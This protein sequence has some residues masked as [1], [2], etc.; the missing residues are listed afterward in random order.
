MWDLWWTKWP[1]DR[2]FP[3]ASASPAK[4]QSTDCSTFIIIHHPGLVEKGKLWP[5]RQVDSVS[6]HPMKLKEKYPKYGCSNF[7]KRTAVG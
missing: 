4:S 7:G 1:W 2:F 6:P 3:S 5:T